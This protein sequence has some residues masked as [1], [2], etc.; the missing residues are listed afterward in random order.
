MGSDIIC[1]SSPWYFKM[2]KGTENSGTGNEVLT[3]QGS[4][5]LAVT[6]HMKCQPMGNRRI[7]YNHNVVELEEKEVA[8]GMKNKNLTPFLPQI[9]TNSSVGGTGGNSALDP[10]QKL[11]VLLR[12]RQKSGSFQKTKA[13]VNHNNH[14][15]QQPWLKQQGRKIQVPVTIESFYL[16]RPRIH[17]STRKQTTL[18]QPVSELTVSGSQREHRKHQ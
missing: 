12:R 10:P 16:K 4:Q 14:Q 15:G 9:Y 11:H 3:R 5:L 1:R 7:I 6:S 13:Y 2:L 8:E 17:K 18:H